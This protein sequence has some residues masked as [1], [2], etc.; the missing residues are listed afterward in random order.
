MSKKE[1]KL[2]TEELGKLQV[3]NTNFQNIKIEIADC[4][5]KKVNLL[6]QLKVYRDEFATIE[7]ELIKTYGDNA[8]INLQTGEVTQPEEENVVESLEKVK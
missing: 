7:K 4:E 8:K 3:L 5:V 1:Q 6:A 2:S